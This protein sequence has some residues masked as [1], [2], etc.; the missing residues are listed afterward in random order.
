MTKEASAVQA[1]TGKAGATPMSGA[2]KADVIPFAQDR[3]KLKT[4]ADIEAYERTPLAARGFPSSTYEALRRARDINPDAPAIHYIENGDEYRS[5][6]TISHGELFA[7]ITQTANLLHRLGV[8]PED[9]VAVLM[10]NVI[11]T[12]YAIWGAEAAGIVCP[13]NWLLEPE[14]IVRLLN[15]A[16]PK[17]LVAFGP[18]PDIDIWNKID[19]IKRQVPTLTHIVKAGGGP[20]GDASVIDFLGALNGLPADRLESGREIKGTDIAS[21][22]HTGGTTGV[23][24]F[25]RHTHANEAFNVCVAGVAT[26]LLPGEV[27]ISG[28]PLFHVTGVIFCSLGP[29]AF[30]C[31]IVMLT[32]LGWRHPTALRNFWEIVQHFR[33]T[34][35][36]IVPTVANALLNIPIGRSDISSLTLVGCGTAPLS[37]HIA[38]AFKDLTGLSVH[39]GYGMTEATALSAV[40][41]RY[42]EVKVGSIGL[43][44]PYQQMKIVSLDGSRDL[45]P[46]EPGIIA[47]KGPSVF[48]GYLDPE[49]NKTAWFEGGWLNSGDLGYVDEDGYF[50]ITGRA[51]DLIIRGGNNIDPRMV[52][53]YFYAH[54]A[55]A[56]AA[57]VGR[58]D[59]H[60]GELPVA[61]LAL[62]PGATADLRRLKFYAYENVPE[63]LGVP[64][65]F[66]VVNALPRTMVGKINKAAL[67]VDAIKRAQ[68]DALGTIDERIEAEVDVRD[69]GEAGVR[70]VITLKHVSPDARERIEGKVYEALKA[71]TVKFELRFEEPTA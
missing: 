3:L 21:L 66:Y 65:A 14:I 6:I 47:L 15:A 22:F 20:V 30:G 4:L 51:K 28:V 42:G 34:G 10:P 43:P 5:A 23:P 40:N 17:V 45:G 48:A 39:E 29:L 26:D 1:R 61:Y 41:P 60:A 24:K 9:V 32:S 13:I 49:H 44:L 7:R 36:T 56:D 16:R 53:E 19:A 57:V 38:K 11:E 12:Q 37:V 33:V 8:G 52:E 71:F 64:K 50:W 25:A 46:N 18:H 35:V 63:R 62:K 54:P 2:E 55:V 31:A 59:T 68:L 67:R 69:L 70:S 58:P 27:V